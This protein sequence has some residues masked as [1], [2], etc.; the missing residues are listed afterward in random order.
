[1]GLFYPSM[2][3]DGCREKPVP[4][5]GIWRKPTPRATLASLAASNSCTLPRIL[6]NRSE[7]GRRMGK[8]FSL[9]YPTAAVLL[10]IRH[11]HRYGFD[12]MDATGL[13]DGTVYPILRRLERRGVLDRGVGGGGGGPRGS[14]PA[15]ALLPA[16]PRRGRPRWRRCS[17]ASPRWLASSRAGGGDG[18]MRPFDRRLLAAASR[19][20][21]FGRRDAWRREWEAE[22]AYAWKVLERSGRTSRL[23]RPA[24]ARAGTHLCDRRPVG[25]EGDDEDDGAAQ[26]S[27]LRRCAVCCGTRRSPPWRC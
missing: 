17:S 23:R 5:V 6:D 14:A 10:A 4:R 3:V 11:G 2:R 26:R 8:L 18:V 21:P 15:A 16:H 24:P 13:P 7:E 1:M 19:L 20:V 12:V 9:T 27:A 22:T 25:A